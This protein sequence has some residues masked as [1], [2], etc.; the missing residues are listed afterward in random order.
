MARA[1]FIM[2]SNANVITKGLTCQSSNV[3]DMHTKISGFVMFVCCLDKQGAGCK[4]V[5]MLVR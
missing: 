1:K 3:L 2:V 5:V 4:V